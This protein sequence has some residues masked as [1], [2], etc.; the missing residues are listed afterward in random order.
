MEFDYVIVGG[1]SAGCVLAN[2]LSAQSRNRVCLI[3]A[4]PDDT[5]PFIRI[6]GGI[7]PLIRSKIWNWQFWTAPQKN[8]GNREMFWPRGRTLGGSSSIN[9]MCYI[10]GHAWDYD[11]WA[12]LGCTGWSYA[13]LLPVFKAG[14]NFEPAREASGSESRYDLRFHGTAG[15]FNVASH[16]YTNPLQH[17]FVS[18][19]LE[20]DHV[21]TEDFNGAQQEGVGFYHTAQIGGERSSNARAYLDPARP[22][23]NLTV[24]CN[25][26]AARV[27]FD[28]KRAVGVRYLCKNRYVDVRAKQEVILAAGAI[29]SPQLLLLS[30]VGPREEIETHGIQVVHELPG[31]GRN[32][33]DHLDIHVTVRD[34]SR[35][36]VSFHPRAWWRTLKA[37]VQYLRGRQG[38]LTSNLAQ[39]GGFIKTDPRQ[40]IPDL[41]WHFLP[42]V[43][44][45]HGLKLRPLFRH[46]AMSLLTCDLR[47]EAPCDCA[48]PTRSIAR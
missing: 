34:R 18:A 15:P 43:Y 38:E 3:E 4:G 13:E 48:A 6:P 36:A 10:R 37:V 11:H 39:A 17:R 22:R 35:Q 46:F 12:S 26:H 19:A 2:R 23:P 21:A 45:N 40:P 20:A 24:I 32:L 7:I 14:E 8:C 1:G 9:A 31:V 5:H 29:G 25:A 44:A 41:Q 42:V 47:A 33:Q 27:L 16:R 28:K 30:G